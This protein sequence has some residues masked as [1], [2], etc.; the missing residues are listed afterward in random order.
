M[1]EYDFDKRPGFR[2]A[3]IAAAVVLAGGLVF[4]FW[5]EER[6]SQER[7]AA[8]VEMERELRPLEQ[9]AYQL[10]RELDELKAEHKDEAQGMGSV[11]ILFSNLDETI[12]KEIYPQ[13]KN[14]GLTGVLTLSEQN[15][16][17]Q[18][19]C[20]S[21]EEFQELISAG[22]DC[23][24]R[25]EGSSADPEEWLETMEGKTESAGIP[26]PE[27]I[28]FPAETYDDEMDRFLAEQGFL[29]AVHHGEKGGSLI[30][31]ASSDGLWHTGAVMWNQSSGRVILGEVISEKGNLVF[32]VGSDGKEEQYEE[33]AYKN[34]LSLIRQYSEADSLKA[35]GL[36]EARE[37][38]QQL[39]E[40]KTDSGYEKQKKE[41]EEQIQ[42][43]DREI[44]AI[45]DKY[46]KNEG[47]R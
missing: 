32:T 38:R 24:L 10:K 13:M 12:Y 30:T 9:D 37:Y 22:W 15:F 19:G 28:Y 34:M 47:R 14:Y 40:L 23:S 5:M 1:N 21:M 33:A 26:L 27:T 25:W 45:T 7:Q 35:V 3:L 8:Y 43:L 11:V 17:G 39:E 20:L 44:E 42:D 6:R 18:K 2:I 16:P 46:M 41:L 31:T 29:A 36:L 4:F